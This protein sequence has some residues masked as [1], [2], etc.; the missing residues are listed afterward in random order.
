[1]P[2]NVEISDELL[3]SLIAR[4]IKVEATLSMF[5][6]LSLQHIADP[7]SRPAFQALIEAFADTRARYIHNQIESFAVQFPH[8][9]K[10]LQDH[11][12]VSEADLKDFLDDDDKA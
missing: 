12:V 8:L 7:N 11:A 1:M 4:L 3:V 10:L 5:A 9:A 2:S 6:Q